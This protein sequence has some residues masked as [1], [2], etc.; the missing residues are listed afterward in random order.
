MPAA[1]ADRGLQRLLLR[2]ADSVEAEV[3]Q[4]SKQPG[5]GRQWQSVGAVA[6]LHVEI[7]DALGHRPAQHAITGQ[8]GARVEGDEQNIA[9]RGIRWRWAK[10]ISHEPEAPAAS[11]FMGDEADR[12]RPFTLANLKFEVDQDDFAGHQAI[13]RRRLITG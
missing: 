11:P 13:P 7:K 10:L 1:V 8:L 9:T 4:G 6:E 12:H 3:G 2:G 5:A